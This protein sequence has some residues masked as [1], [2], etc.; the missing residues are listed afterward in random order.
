MVNKKLVLRSVIFYENL[1]FKVCF[2]VKN[3]NVLF[4]IITK[5]FATSAHFLL[6]L[7]HLHAVSIWENLNA[8]SVFT[9]VHTVCVLQ[10]MRALFTH[11]AYSIQ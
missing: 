10:Y 9:F 8:M 5:P 7:A 4:A 11:T 2:V 6:P 3:K 1:W